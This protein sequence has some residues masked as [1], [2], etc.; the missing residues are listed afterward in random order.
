M[1]KFV[2][3]LFVL[4]LTACGSPEVNTQ[5]QSTVERDT[6]G[7]L[8]YLPI[9]EYPAGIAYCSGYETNQPIWE[10]A[11]WADPT[12]SGSYQLYAVSPDF[13][14]VV[15]DASDTGYVVVKYNDV[16]LHLP[17]K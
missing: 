6:W 10:C 5:D 15:F 3:V 1:K 7:E 4:A 13:L 8:E 11:L 17:A 2:I 9:G 12:R 14:R 16:L